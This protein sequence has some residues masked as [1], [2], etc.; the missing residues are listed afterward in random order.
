MLYDVIVEGHLLDLPPALTPPIVNVNLLPE[1]DFDNIDFYLSEGLAETPGGRIWCAWVS[2]GDSEKAYFVLNWSDDKGKTWTKPQ[3]VID[4]HETRFSEERRSVVG[5]PWTAPN[6]DLWLFFDQSMTM[7]DGRDGLWY[8][9]CKNPDSNK[10]AW[11]TPVRIFHGCTLNKPIVHSSGAWILPVSL[12]RRWKMLTT[13]KNANAFTEL[14]PERNAKVMVSLDEGKTWESRGNVTLENAICSYDEH[15][16]TELENGRLWMTLR[17]KDGIWQ[18]F[19]DDTGYTW[20]D[21][22]KYL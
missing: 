4:P 2:G 17:S 21:P 15:H 22:Q 3:V 19:S 5:V 20:S 13:Y 6:G 16:I 8:T 11:T 7:F 18:S 14:D 9:I 1:Y 12:W 10:P